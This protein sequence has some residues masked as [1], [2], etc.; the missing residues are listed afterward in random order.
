MRTFWLVLTPSKDCLK[1]SLVVII[2]V[3][4]GSKVKCLN[5]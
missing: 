4:E 5:D 1:V 2:S 3:D